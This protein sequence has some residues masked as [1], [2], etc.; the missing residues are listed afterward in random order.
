MGHPSLLRLLTALAFVCAWC[1]LTP[2]SAHAQIAVDVEMTDG[3]VSGPADPDAGAPPSGAIGDAGVVPQ[4]VTP[5]A[6]R[7]RWRRGGHAR[8]QRRA[9]RVEA[10]QGPLPHRGQGHP[11]HHALL[12]RAV[13]G[14]RPV[15]RPVAPVLRRL[16]HSPRD[17]VPRGGHGDHAGVAR[18][19]LQQ[20]NVVV[21]ASTPRRRH[22][23]LQRRRARGH[24]GGRA[25]R[26]ALGRQRL[27][28]RHARSHVRS[29]RERHQRQLDAAL[30]GQLRSVAP[31]RSE[32]LPH[33]PLRRAADFRA[34]PLR[35][36]A[37]SHR[38]DPRR[39]A[40]V[41]AR[42]WRRRERR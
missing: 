16:R 29:Q 20:E 7:R 13:V 18:P 21:R 40:A 31:G 3:G 34:S 22:G 12:D 17:R 15:G 6:R 37:H 35:R 26:R 10:G 30:H 23:R 39:S 42:R 5:A 32:R 41:H 2:R 8:R 24:L 38:H 9:A 19:G 1:G 25:G 28:R 27:V 11:A 4:V 36:G 33:G 14:Q